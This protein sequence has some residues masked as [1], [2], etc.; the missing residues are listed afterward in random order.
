MKLKPAILSTLT[1]DDLKR[2]VDDLEIDGVDRRS[3][4][5]MR[6]A[7]KRARRAK[8][9]DLLGYLK[10]GQLKE[11]CEALGVSAKRKRDDLVERLLN[12]EPVPKQSRKKK[13]SIA[14]SSAN[15]S[16][17][18]QK[19]LPLNGN[20]ELQQA[21]ARQ[22]KVEKLTLARLEQK[23]FKGCDILRGNMDASEYKEYIF[24][25]LFLKRMSDQFEKDQAALRAQYEK[26]G[27]KPALIEKQL[28]NPD[29]YD[30]FVPLAACWNA[31]NEKGRKTG[32]AH[33]KQSV[34]SGLNKALAAI[35]DANP[36]TLQDVLKTI[37]FNRKVGQRTMDGSTLIDFIQ[38]FDDIPLSND[39]F[40]FPDLLG[41]AYEYLIKYF[42]D[43]AG[44]KG[45]EFYTPSEVV[46]TMVQII[47]PQE[48]MAVYDPCAGSGGMLIQSKQYVQET[49]GDS[50]NLFLAGQD[51]NGG[52]WA[53][54]KMNMM[55][56][57]IRSADIRQGDTIK[58]PQHLAENGEIRR[59]DRCLRSSR[60]STGRRTSGGFGSEWPIIRPRWACSPKR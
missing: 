4:D 24:G 41:S 54:C 40:E 7:I 32:I 57:G 19:M 45:G 49:G 38:H 36:D 5:A 20:G 16:G 25:M 22:K 50:R 39:D 42:A 2:I 9:D 28:A 35:E 3:A 29:K 31:T 51:S 55:L 43:S 17:K 44:K 23:L 30:F 27:L 15:K 33:L 52:T 1:R 48:D 59:F 46:R 12:G 14:K 58:D 11:V 8:L 60:H 18:K 53:I 26:Q 21:A 34:G 47:Q 37:N 56:H 6:T 13:T 10:K